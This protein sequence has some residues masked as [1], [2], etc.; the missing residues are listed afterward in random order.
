MDDDKKN[1]PEFLS[2]SD[3]AVA[4]AY[5]PAASGLPRVTAKGSGELAEELIGLALRHNIPIKYDPDL[6][7]VLSTLEVGQDI[8]EEIFLIVAE[9]LAFIY[10]VNQDFFP[11]RNKTED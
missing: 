7:Q 6:I 11:E 3:E 9:I 2:G 8:P 1:K 4:L 5:D 10:R